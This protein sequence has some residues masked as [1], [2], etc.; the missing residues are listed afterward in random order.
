MADKQANLIAGKLLAEIRAAIQ[1]TRNFR[2]DGAAFTNTPTGA[3][4]VIPQAKPSR[5]AIVGKKQGLIAVNVSQTGGSNGT[6]STAASYTYTV[7]DAVTGE[8]LGSSMSPVWARTVGAV[9]AATHG[10]AYREA[11]GDVVLYQV[12]EVPEVEACA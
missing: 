1:W 10:T 7:T 8:T 6:Q 11:D 2:V 12:D 3:T 9:T 5:Q 4:I